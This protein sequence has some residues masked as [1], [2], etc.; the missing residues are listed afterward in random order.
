[1]IGNGSHHLSG[2]QSR[3]PKLDSI[4]VTHCQHIIKVHLLANF[5]TQALHVNKVTFTDPVLF[6]TTLNNCV[7]NYSPL[8]RG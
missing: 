6:S 8:P 7:Q 3:G 2:A 5:T 4:L 1:M